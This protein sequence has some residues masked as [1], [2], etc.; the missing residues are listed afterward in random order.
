ML[1]QQK[2]ES[3][4]GIQAFQARPDSVPQWLF[5]H[6]TTF[7]VT[8][9]LINSYYHVIN[10]D[11]HSGVDGNKENTHAAERGKCL[12]HAARKKHAARKNGC[13]LKR[14]KENSKKKYAKSASSRPK[15]CPKGAY[16]WRT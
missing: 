7:K 4:G 8:A 5:L 1:R 9:I 10:S 15:D 12:P 16:G 2:R 6:F 3:A 13:N 14:K 11:R